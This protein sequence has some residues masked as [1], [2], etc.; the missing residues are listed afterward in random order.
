MEL[1]EREQQLKKI[2]EAWSQVRAGQ[3]GT[4]LVSGEAGIEKTS[5]QLVPC[6]SEHPTQQENFYKYKN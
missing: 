2:M 4:A 6:K 3:G 5:L 1:I